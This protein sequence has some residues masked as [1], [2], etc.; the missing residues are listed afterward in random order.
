MLQGARPF[1][2]RRPSVLESAAIN[3]DQFIRRKCGSARAI[4]STRKRA[5]FG[6]MWYPDP[7]VAPQFDL[8]V[9]SEGSLVARK[10]PSWSVAELR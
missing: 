9:V 6:E 5:F 2:I 3:L 4:V 10:E 8:T 1:Q 7:C